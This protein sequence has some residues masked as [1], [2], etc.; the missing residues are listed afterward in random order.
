M[1]TPLYFTASENS[2]NIAVL[3]I[4]HFASRTSADIDDVTP[5]MIAQ[6]NNHHQMVNLL[7]DNCGMIPSPTRIIPS[8]T[9]SPAEVSPQ[10]IYPNI[11]PKLPKLQAPLSNGHSLP[12]MQPKRKRKKTG[13]L[14]MTTS[15]SSKQPGIIFTETPNTKFSFLPTDPLRELPDCWRMFPGTQVPEAV[16]IGSNF[17]GTFDATSCGESEVSPSCPPYIMTPPQSWPTSSPESL[18]GEDAVP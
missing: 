7:S 8:P 6:R 2:Y 9:L 16:F 13:Q 1:K 5:L 15:P 14:A 11:R 12:S 10:P 17:N 4:S 18:G 3:L